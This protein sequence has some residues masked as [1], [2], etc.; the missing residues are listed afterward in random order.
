[1]VSL[2]LLLL[3]SLVTCTLSGPA[4][5]G[6]G[7]ARPRS[8]DNTKGYGA[9][10]DIDNSK[11]HGVNIDDDNS[12]C[13]GA[14]IQNSSEECQECSGP[15]CD[16]MGKLLN[17]LIDPTVD[18][19]DD[20]FA[21]ACSVKAR[22]TPSPI[23]PIELADHKTLI[24]FPPEGYDYIREFYQSCTAIEDGY[25]TEQVFFASCIKNDGECTEEEMKQYGDIYVQFFRYTKEFFKKT[26]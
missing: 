4:P 18:P 1:M 2:S 23:T 22:G 14:N 24:Q 13:H 7:T 11:C 15:E 9:N 20:F 17:Y 16:E 10:I 21:Y 12:K 5:S 8:I 6:R 25:T 26:S 3:L 19:C